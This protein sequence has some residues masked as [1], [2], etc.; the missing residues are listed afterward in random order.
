MTR[1]LIF[2]AT[3]GL[4]LIGYLAPGTAAQSIRRVNPKYVETF[5]QDPRVSGSL[6][7]GLAWG[8]PEGSPEAKTVAKFDAEQVG[9]FLFPILRGR[10]ACVEVSSQ[11]GRY[12]AQNLYELP[13]MQGPEDFD[14][15]THYREQLNHYSVSEMAVSIRLVNDCN[16]AEQG[17]LVPARMNNGPVNA[18]D[19]NGGGRPLLAYFNAD[20]QR[21]TV[22]LQRKGA[23]E[24]IRGNC[25]TEE[26]AVKISFSSACKFYGPP[27]GDY[28]LIVELQERFKPQV[29]RFQ[30]SIR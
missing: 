12:F 22:S 7:V 2:R 6:L 30:V 9:I 4:C 14:A 17:S 23:A 25:R 10:K 26:S 21:L 29:S 3:F 20:S 19:A 27:P 28:E 1:Q 5:V 18:S 16:S 13:D 24:P 11:D 8:L 15:S